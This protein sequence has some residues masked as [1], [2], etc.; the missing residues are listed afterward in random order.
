MRSYLLGAL[1]FCAALCASAQ[2][3]PSAPSALAAGAAAG[4]AEFATSEHDLAGQELAS[5]VVRLPLRS[6]ETESGVLEDRYLAS[7]LV[8]VPAHQER[9]KVLDRNF[10]LLM[11]IGSA[12]TVIDF[13]MTQSCLAKRICREANPLVPTSRTAVYATNIPFNAA[14]YY[15]SYKR[16]KSGKRLWWVAPLVIVGSHAVGVASNVPF[17]GKP[18]R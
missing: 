10:L 17:V 8:P 3:L 6:L 12:L 14:L 4:N 18:A 11:G 16:K 7:P 13:E 1:L 5:L 9:R 15:W 2:E